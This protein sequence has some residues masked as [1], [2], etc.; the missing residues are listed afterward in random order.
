[1]ELIAPPE[2]LSVCLNCC[3]N[4]RRGC[5][6]SFGPTE[7][8]SPKSPLHHPKP[9]LHQCNPISRQ[10]QRLFA[11]WL[12]KTCCT[13]STTF[14]SFPFSGTFPGSW[15][16]KTRLQIRN[17]RGFAKVGCKRGAELR[18]EEKIRF[19]RSFSLPTWA[20]WLGLQDHLVEFLFKSSG[21]GGFLCWIFRRPFFRRRF[22][23][24]LWKNTH[25][26]FGE[27]IRRR[28]FVFRFFSSLC[29]SLFSSHPILRA[30]SFKPK[31][32]AQN[33][34]CEKFFLTKGVCQTVSP[35]FFLKVKQKT[36]RTWENRKETG[37]T[38]KKEERK[39]TSEKMGDWF[40]YTSSAGRRCPFAI[41]SASGV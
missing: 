12:Q 4:G 24:S 10:R 32:F 39:K 31:H 38:T 15:L 22:P 23:F 25:G 17:L 37:K 11:R 2:F 30:T 5:K 28:T 6:R 16:P 34:L 33:S 20:H 27:N 26:K 40:L 21:S 29:F 8:R 35:R 36:R 13:L 14:G 19:P 9:L 1:M 7:Q 41:F 3:S 18:V